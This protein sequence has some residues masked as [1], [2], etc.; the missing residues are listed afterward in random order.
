[1]QAP[2]QKAP[3]AAAA[4]AMAAVLL[5]NVAP[6][7]A[8]TVKQVVCASNP[9]SKVRDGAASLHCSISSARC[10]I[11][12]I[13]LHFLFCSHFAVWWY[14]PTPPLVHVCRSA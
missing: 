14:Q 11:V 7:S 12:L 5:V 10:S 8:A 2:V 3:I 9:T 6:A 13:E 1:L 4:L